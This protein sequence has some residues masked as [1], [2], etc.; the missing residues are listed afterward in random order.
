MRDELEKTQKEGSQVYATRL[1]KRSPKPYKSNTEFLSP[2][3]KQKDRY[4]EFFR[5]SK[6][7]LLLEAEKERQ[8][9]YDLQ[10]KVDH[11][12]E[13]LKSKRNEDIEINA[14]I[15]AEIMKS[16]SITFD[17]DTEKISNLITEEDG[18]L[19]IEE[20]RKRILDAAN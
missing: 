6:T 15:L 1:R 4:R 14:H 3:I 5:T 12:L 9:K 10:S 2:V 11:F 20:M 19:N 7:S 18:H 8:D 17:V 16:F 13:Q